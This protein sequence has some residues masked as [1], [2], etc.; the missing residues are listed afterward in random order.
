MPDR[1]EWMK[2]HEQMP[3]GGPIYTETNPLETIMEPWNAVSSMAFLIPAFYWL[4]KCRG[5]F[6]ENSFLLACCALLAVGGLGSTLFHAFRKYPLLLVMDVLPIIALTLLVSI[7][8]WLKVIPRW[9]LLIPILVPALWLRY[10][11]MSKLHAHEGINLGYFISGTLIFLPI[12]FL[13]IRTKFRHWH[14]ILFAILFLG[15]ALYFRKIDAYDPPLLAI[16]THW[17]WH[18]LCA[19]GAYFLGKYIYNHENLNGIKRHSV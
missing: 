1:T 5:Q 18:L 4:W 17:L 11:A 14:A 10:W 9:W 6:R 15:L 12:A 19:T 16:G 7:Y 2:L 3:D 13:L 8:F